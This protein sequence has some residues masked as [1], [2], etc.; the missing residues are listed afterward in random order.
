MSTDQV[1]EDKPSSP[2]LGLGLSEGLGCNAQAAARERAVLFSAPMVR[3]LLAGTKTQ[4]RRAVNLP[5]DAKHV[6]YW[7]PPS[8]RSESGYADPGVNYWTPDPA[9]ETDSNHL[10]PCPYGQPGDRLWVRET[11]QY[12]D[13]TEDGQPYVRLAADN[14]VRF[15][16]G[17][18]EG[19][20][21]VDVWAELSDPTNYAIDN[22]A[23][24][25][26]W[27]PPIFMP[28]WASRITLE[29][30][31]VRVER[32]RDIS[33]AD[34]LAEGVADADEGSNLIKGSYAITNFAN[35]WY[36]INS[37]RGYGWD[38]NPYVWVVEFKKV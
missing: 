15:C 31:G 7:A 6:C 12:A 18:G 16:D 24:D 4:T 23:A 11:W 30:T 34:A 5:A 20:T 38:S 35:L 8:G 10:N 3:A 29:I 17:A 33:H 27:R 14:T 22:K 9:G 32:V 21:L 37:K 25:R 28:R 36:T 26:K 1:P 2:L 19:E 13:W